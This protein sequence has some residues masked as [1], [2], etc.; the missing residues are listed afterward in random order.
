MSDPRRAWQGI[1]ARG[2]PHGQAS[3]RAGAAAL[4]LAGAAALLLAGAGT[5]LLSGAGAEDARPKEPLRVENAWRALFKRD[6][7]PP[8]PPENP[9][10][11]AKVTLGAR[12]FSDP[13]LSGDGRRSC[14]S[15]HRPELA[16]SD[17]RRRAQGLNGEALGR[18]TPSL[19][20]LAW[21]S[22]YFWDGRAASL[23]AQVVMPIAAT[24]E[25]GGD[26]L[27]ILRRLN[28]DAG[29]LA[30]F[31]AA[32]PGQTRIAEDNVAKALAAYVRSLIS[33]PTRFDA[34]IEGDGRALTANEV[35][36]FRLFSGKAG[37]VLC[38]VGWRFTDDRFHDI[39][40][41]S[42]DMG[43]G[44]VAGGTPGLP[45]FKT[46]SLREAA[47]TAPYMHDGSRATLAAVIKHYAGG[48][49][50]RPSLAP[51]LQR[52]L[53]LTKREQAD[54]LAF[55]G[56]LSGPGTPGQQRQAGRAPAGPPRPPAP[57]R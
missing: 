43:R 7:Q 6:V 19:F 14:A 15:C 27:E 51:S 56:T 55:L 8:A 35:R 53:T 54:L 25:M 57:G 3:L 30:A 9:S 36:G 38:H 10:T 16:F 34:W 45:A 4:L 44:L 13:R 32:F 2:K 1:A 26:W 33:Q 48:L 29:L 5:L 18:N 46:P 40:L 41:A 23:E 42:G 21:S 22:A 31:Q 24:Q 37:C 47:H 17:G 28:G 49:R 39:G 20:N 11:P 12:L 50:Q 52:R